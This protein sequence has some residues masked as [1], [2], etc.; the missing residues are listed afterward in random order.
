MDQLDKAEQLEG[1]LT[2]HR[3]QISPRIIHNFVKN[4]VVKEMEDQIVLKV[5]YRRR[6]AH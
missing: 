2:D 4:I 3:F 6:E 1:N 5:N